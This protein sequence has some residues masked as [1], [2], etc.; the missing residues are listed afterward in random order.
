MKVKVEWQWL[1]SEQLFCMTSVLCIFF[2]A[3]ALNAHSEVP[4][5]IMSGSPSCS[6]LGQTQWSS[7]EAD[8]VW[9]DCLL[10]IFWGFCLFI[11]ATSCLICYFFYLNSERHFICLEWQ[12]REKWQKSYHRGVCL[13]VVFCV[14]P[15]HSL[16]MLI[17][18]SVDDFISTTDFLSFSSFRK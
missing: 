10:E 1:A 18:H 9:A 8:K 11:A 2:L 16:D 3:L 13:F 17:L 5:W 4:L 14:L 12:E 6:N 15:S 7:W